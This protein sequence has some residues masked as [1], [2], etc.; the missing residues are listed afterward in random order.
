MSHI[1]FNSTAVS[2][3]IFTTRNEA[4]SYRTYPKGLRIVCFSASRREHEPL[5][6]Q[7]APLAPF[8]CTPRVVLNFPNAKKLKAV[9]GHTITLIQCLETGDSKTGAFVIESQLLT[10]IKHKAY[11]G[12]PHTHTCLLYTSRCV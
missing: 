8:L 9:S 11:G 12:I 7:L 1:L 3:L 6:N 10:L 2:Y 4:L 5:L